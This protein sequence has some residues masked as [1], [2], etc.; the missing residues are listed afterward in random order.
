[1]KPSI[2]CVAI[3]A[4]LISCNVHAAE[5]EKPKKRKIVVPVTQRTP[6]D[7][8]V[9]SESPTS[10]KTFAPTWIELQNKWHNKLKKLHL[11]INS[12]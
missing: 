5:V 4:M 11:N 3:S 12:D 7:K 2:K 8:P 1:M 9:T 6:T 10:D